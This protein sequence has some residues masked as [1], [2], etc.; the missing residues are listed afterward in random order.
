MHEHID[1]FGIINMNGRV[2]DP[3]TA[4]FFSPD[5]YL[6]APGNWLNYNRYS[7]CWN[8]PFKYTDPS[9][10]EVIVIIA[11]IAGAI[12]GSYVGGVSVNHG[13]LNPVHWDWQDPATYIFM[14][15]GAIIGAVAGYGIA[16][17]GSVTFGVGLF[18][19]NAWGG[20]AVGISGIGGG[21]S[22]AGWNFHW[23][24]SAGGGGE[25]YPN[26]KKS[27][28][29][30]VAKSVKNGIDAANNKYYIPSGMLDYESARNLM[31]SWSRDIKVETVIY[32]TSKGWYLEYTEGR[33][34]L[35]NMMSPYFKNTLLESATYSL[36]ND[37][38]GNPQIRPSIHRGSW[39]DVYWMAH[40]HP[41]DTKP[42]Q[43][44]DIPFI[45]NRLKNQP[46]HIWSWGVGYKNCVVVG[47]Q[48]IYF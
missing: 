4:S 40:T 33:H 6:Q 31:T 32:N 45:R 24:T 28:Q 9:G 26:K 20:I 5:P 41:F 15:V 25:Y 48:I 16:V 2:Y 46:F 13:Q 18:A 7:Y 3:L 8:N 35:S 29:E 21:G 11:V 34:T 43:D 10:E 42:S 22:M 39:G 23:T 37:S 17:P 1:Q 36:H 47:G 19:E 30:V 27:E 44:L 14:G 12:I 38:R